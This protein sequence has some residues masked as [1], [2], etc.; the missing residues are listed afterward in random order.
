MS[1]QVES[2]KMQARK[3]AC[4]KTKHLRR[5]GIETYPVLREAAVAVACPS[6][7]ELN[8]VQI[9]KQEG[10]IWDQKSMGQAFEL[11]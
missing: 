1:P 3:F 7:A 11:R 10:T 2:P 4:P 6:E 5:F 8:D 9:K